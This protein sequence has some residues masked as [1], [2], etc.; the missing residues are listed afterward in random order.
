MKKSLIYY[1]QKHYKNSGELLEV[2]RQIYGSEAYET[3]G[4][5]IGPAGDK[6][7]GLFDFLV[8]V[9][10]T[11]ACC[12]DIMSMTGILAELHA[13][14]QFDSILFPATQT[15]RMLA[16]RLAMRLRAGLIADITEIRQNNGLVEI[17][18]PAFGGKLMAGIISRTPKPL[19][20]S[21]RQNV[22]SYH[23]EE[24]KHTIKI[25]YGSSA[26]NQNGVLP[27][28][29]GSISSRRGLR[30]IEVREKE[31][32]KDIRDSEI[33]IS[34]GGGVM[35]DF[36]KLEILA[37][38]MN[39][40]VSASRKTVDQ[41]IAPRSIQVGQS[42]KTVSPRLYVALGINGSIQHI[43]G[44]KNIEA[45]IAV[46]T[47]KNAPICSISDIVVEGDAKEFIDKLTNKIKQE[48]LKINEEEKA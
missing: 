40:Q 20:M 41:G 27:E 24:R 11:H 43:E 19:M 16:P 38:E 1:E 4:V 46:N 29:D 21:V 23:Q 37:E 26:S 15:G 35:R 13:V 48:K 3:Y 12:H 42:G 39:A 36:Q 10:D 25:S 17:V 18:R 44:L 32:S 31:S 8:E 33:L 28:N 22:F 47:N 14:Y 30:L 9:P 2:A 6:A 34:G 5:S 45:I 7:E